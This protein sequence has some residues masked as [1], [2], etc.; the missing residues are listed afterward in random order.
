MLLLPVVVVVV[1][2]SERARRD[3]DMGYSYMR[4]IVLSMPRVDVMIVCYISGL[5][6][7]RANFTRAHW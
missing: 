2:V 4:S 6:A 3:E 7:T 5:W 1:A